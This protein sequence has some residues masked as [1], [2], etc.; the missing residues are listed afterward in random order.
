MAIVW[1]I[2][3]NSGDEDKTDSRNLEM[4]S[5][6]LEN[7]DVTGPA[8]VVAER[9]CKWKRSFIFAVTAS[10]TTDKAQ[11]IFIGGERWCM[12]IVW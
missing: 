9:W 3:Y 6:K 2:S 1:G 10:G 12:S 11:P 7:L 4:N 8:H 5:L